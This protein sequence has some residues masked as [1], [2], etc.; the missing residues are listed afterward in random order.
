[1]NDEIDVRSVLPDDPRSRARALPRHEYLREATRYMGER[2]PG[3]GRR[4]SGCRPPPVGGRP[5]GRAGRDRGV[6]RRASSRDGQPDVILTTV[7]AAGG[8]RAEPR[9]RARP[10]AR[11]RGAPSRRRRAACARASTARRAR[12]AAR[13]A[14]SVERRAAR[15]RAHGRVR[16]PRR[17]GCAAPASRSPPRVAGG[18]APGE[19]LVTS[20]VRDLV[21]GAGW[22][23]PSAGQSRCR[24]GARRASGGCSPSAG[25]T[26]RRVPGVYRA[27][28][29]RAT[30][31][32]VHRP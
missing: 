26:G 17:R 24:A 5:G 11:F 7:L 8:R 3:P 9:P 12:F 25:S 29:R 20:T 10:A 6:P 32:G 18:R 16:A 2:I 1:M 21:A 4:A 15:G 13:G 22:R 23:S 14:A 27:R 19:V 28:S 31:T 30:R